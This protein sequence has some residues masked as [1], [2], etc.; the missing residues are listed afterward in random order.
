MVPLLV[1]ACAGAAQLRLLYQAPQITHLLTSELIFMTVLDLRVAVRQASS[2]TCSTAILTMLWFTYDVFF[3]LK[4]MLTTQIYC[5][6]LNL[7]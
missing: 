7:I 6:Y 5:W 4:I 1:V 3:Y 2:K